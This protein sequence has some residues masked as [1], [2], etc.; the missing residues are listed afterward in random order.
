MRPPELFKDVEQIT[1]LVIERVGK[2]ILLGLPL[3]L[4]KANSLA[5]ALYARALADPEIQLTIYTALTLDPPRVK[6]ELAQRFIE[7]MR[8]RF[9]DGYPRLSYARALQEHALPD[10]IQVH[11]FFLQPGQWL[12]NAQMQQDYVA[13]NYTHVLRFLIDAGINVI[14]QLI[15]PPDY[16][17]D[18]MLADRYSLSCNPDLSADLLDLR[19][20]GELTCV[21]VGEVNR[22]LPY[23]YGAADRDNSDFDFILDQG[24]AGFA[25][26]TPPQEPVTLTDHAIGLQVARLILDGGTLQIGIGSMGDAIAHG[27]I[28][29]DAHND[30]FRNSINNLLAGQHIHSDNLAPFEQGLY[31]LSEMLTEGF[32]ALLNAGIIRR[33]VDGCLIHASFFVGSPHFYRTLAALDKRLHK[34]IS[35]MPVSY[36]NQ[37]YGDEWEKRRAR[38][39]ARFVNSAII[40]TLMGDVVSDGTENGQ[41]IS[42]VGGQYNFAAQAFA[43]N[44]ARSIIT[45]RATRQRHGKTES[46]IRW[47]YGHTT[48][49]RHLRDII[50]TEYGVADLRGK[51]DAQ[52]IAA[53]LNITDSRFQ[54]ELLQQAKA[55]KKIAADYQIP[56]EFC[57]NTPARIQKALA[58]SQMLEHLPT[59]PVGCDFTREEQQLTLALKFLN[60]LSGS[61]PK[62]LSLAY[63]GLRSADSSQ[64][65]ACL[66][67]MD[68]AKPKSLKEKFYRYL[69]LGALAKANQQTPSRS[70]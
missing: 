40:A 18:G 30:I 49:P 13:L 24:T 19:R 46:N 12:G 43:L 26:F 14:G 23:M 70:D 47:R 66:K 9:F 10:N 64:H 5:N 67:R 69:V 63:D 56:R 65:N 41:V 36:V 31:G 44:G 50:V 48:L 57:R 55:A 2:R 8:E 27:L 3:G 7:P 28:L 32:L 59:F 58:N 37:L 33:E 45:L 17:P 34:K 68:L 62:L 22:H 29:R 52:V 11:E 42:G 21:M 15:A 54:N 53:M 4:G 20:S 60:G 1:D 51:S 38:L 61:T 25:L 39:D 16:L 35:M 6:N